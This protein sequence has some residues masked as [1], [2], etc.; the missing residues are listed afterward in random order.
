M[1]HFCGGKRENDCRVVAT[2]QPSKKNVS[3]SVL[4]LYLH[5]TID[6][7]YRIAVVILS[8]AIAM[9]IEVFYYIHT[10]DM[11]HR[12]QFL[13]DINRSTELRYIAVLRHR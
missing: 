1:P 7:P 3:I 6:N 4:L 11:K 2:K 13:L 10:T 9:I 5:T 8:R 12:L